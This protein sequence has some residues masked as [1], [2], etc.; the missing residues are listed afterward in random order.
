MTRTS[1]ADR[2]LPYFAAFLDLVGKKVVIVGGGKVATTKVRALLP[3]RP[4]PL[5]VMAP[6]VSTFIRRAAAGGQWDGRQRE[7][8]RDVLRGAGRAFGAPDDRALNPRFAGE[9]R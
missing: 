2:G 1:P 8:E 5:V 4:A 3:C 7:R 9:G 6:R